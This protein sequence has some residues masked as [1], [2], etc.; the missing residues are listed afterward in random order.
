MGVIVVGVDGSGNSRGALDWA[1]EEA[2][3]RGASVRTVHAWMLPT[4]GTGEAPWALVPPAGYMDW[5]S[6]EIETHGRAA[7]DREVEDALARV[8]AVVDVERLVV[9]GPA[10][11]A[12]VDASSDAELVVVGTHGRGALATLVLGSVSHHV[13]HHVHSAVVV[14]PEHASA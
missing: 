1:L 14:V 2:R 11:D 13:L 4:V 3:L 6:D 12:I 7:L 10:G 9:E 8:G 5:S